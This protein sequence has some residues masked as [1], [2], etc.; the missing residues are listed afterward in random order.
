MAEIK[1]GADHA[2]GQVIVDLPAEGRLV[3]VRLS[4]KAA[5]ELAQGINDAEELI[6]PPS[7]LIVGKGG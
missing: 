6:N 4:P 1:V 3:R 2:T 7:K 5:R